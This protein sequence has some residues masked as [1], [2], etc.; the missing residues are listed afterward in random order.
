LYASLIDRVHELE[1]G[2]G[3]L[4]HPEKLYYVVALLRNEV[5]NGG[6][7]Q[8]FF[9]SAG[10]YYDDIEAG[11]DELGAAQALE[12]LRKAK[13]I[14]FPGMA[15]PAETTARRNHMANLDPDPDQP[16]LTRKLDKLDRRFYSSP[17]DITP[18]LKAFAKEN[19]LVEEG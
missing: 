8:F 16:E 13:E 7:H 5:N 12:L 1:G 17:D 10:S 6:F 11:L 18:R 9:N 2:Y 19:K 15:V 14:I 3:A 4:S